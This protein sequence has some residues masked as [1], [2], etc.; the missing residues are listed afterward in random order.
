[1]RKKIYKP[2]AAKIPAIIKL[3]SVGDSLAMLPFQLHA[4][5]ETLIEM[6]TAE[7]C[8]NVSKQLC[9]IAGAISHANRGAPILGKRDASSLAINSAIQAVDDVVQ[10]HDRTGAVAVSELEAKTIRA[11]AGKLDDAL[12]AI[13][14]LCYR[15]AEREV[16]QWLMTK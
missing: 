16:S 6:P 2:R 13:P 11:A 15:K 3:E 12:Y 10:R 9:I 7:H 1:M 8:N 4:Q 14:L 5:I